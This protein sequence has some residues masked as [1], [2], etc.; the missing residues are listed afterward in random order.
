MMAALPSLPTQHLH[1]LHMYSTW[2]VVWSHQRL[3]VSVVCMGF[4]KG[5]MDLGRDKNW[6]RGQKT[7]PLQSGF[8][9]CKIVK[10]PD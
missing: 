2:V 4:N 7:E 6:L 3:S 10:V 1:I 8:L 9:I 5:A